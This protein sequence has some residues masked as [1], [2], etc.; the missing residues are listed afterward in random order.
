MARI[1][2]SR[3][4]TTSCGL[5]AVQALLVVVIVEGVVVVVLSRISAVMLDVLTFKDTSELLSAFIRVVLAKL[6]LGTEDWLS[7]IRFASTCTESTRRMGGVKGL[8]RLNFSILLLR[9]AG[10]AVLYPRFN[11]VVTLLD[12]SLKTGEDVFANWSENA[13]NNVKPS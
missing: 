12:R 1:R 3:K 11:S 7:K 10:K 13:L 4:E 6:A 8:P 9:Y 5:L 2:G